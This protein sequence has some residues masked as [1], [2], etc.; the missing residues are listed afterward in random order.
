[1]SLL[2]SS[3]GVRS[4]DWDQWSQPSEPMRQGTSVD[5]AAKYQPRVPQPT[6]RTS[7]VLV[8][9]N[10]G[11]GA[12]DNASCEPA[13]AALPALAHNAW[14]VPMALSEA[15]FDRLSPRCGSATA[16]GSAP[17][18]L[19]WPARPSTPGTYTPFAA[20]ASSGGCSMPFVGTSPSGNGGGTMR[21]ATC[22]FGSDGART[23]T[24]GRR[25]SGEAAR[26]CR[27]HNKGA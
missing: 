20:R 6:L 16:A 26:M 5:M 11:A 8:R 24:T 4:L 3:P 7:Q 2:I 13:E 17:P 15:H 25:V 10:D 14:P 19:L 18:I 27:R 22:D 9:S 1:M 21:H 23:A 12:V